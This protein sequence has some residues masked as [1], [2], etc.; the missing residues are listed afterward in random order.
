MVG[1]PNLRQYFSVP[2]SA[3]GFGWSFSWELLRFNCLFICCLKRMSER[4]NVLCRSVIRDPWRISLLHLLDLLISPRKFNI[5][6]SGEP[7][8]LVPP[9]QASFVHDSY[10]LQ[11]CMYKIWLPAKKSY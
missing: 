4:F 6:V 5:L 7:A 10:T 9:R 8:L 11:S 1:C 3:G 2:I